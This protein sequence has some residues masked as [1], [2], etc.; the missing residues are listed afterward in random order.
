[1]LVNQGVG[2]SANS[3]S[4]VSKAN[5]NDNALFAGSGGTAA[6]LFPGHHHSTKGTKGPV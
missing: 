2:S 5:H 3:Q 6:H 4:D 1:M